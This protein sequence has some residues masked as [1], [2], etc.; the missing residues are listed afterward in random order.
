[1]GNSGTTGRLLA[2]I[3]S[4]T[5]SKFY[6][7]GDQSMNKRDM[8]RVIK[9][10][11]KIGAFFS[12]KNKST[13]PL[14]IQGTSLPLAQTHLE[15]LGSAQVKSSIL[16]AALNT[17]GVT[18]LIE[19]KASRNHTE[20]FLKKI[21]ANIKVKKFKKV[22]QQP[23]LLSSEVL[24]EQVKRGIDHPRGKFQILRFIGLLVFEVH[25]FVFNG[26]FRLRATPQFF[27]PE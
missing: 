10:L 6:L 23:H 9:P 5:P 2:G 22:T 16:L 12:P 25:H 1:M 21:G 17:P 18:T 19:Q 7:Y 26:F 15:I 13:L 27:R 24:S 11:E 8:S 3:C 14:I 20:I 4:T